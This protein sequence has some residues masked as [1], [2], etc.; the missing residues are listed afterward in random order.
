MQFAQLAISQLG[1]IQ[2]WHTHKLEALQLVEDWIVAK[3]KGW[4][5]GK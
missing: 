2:D 1:R 5:N 4:T 3:R